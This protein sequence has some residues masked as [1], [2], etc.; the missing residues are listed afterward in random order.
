LPGV[1]R[2]AV[3]CDFREDTPPVTLGALNEFKRVLRVAALAK[4][5]A[6]IGGSHEEF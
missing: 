1:C 2:D 4:S 5:K 3:H 6:P